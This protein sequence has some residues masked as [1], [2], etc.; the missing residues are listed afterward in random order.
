MK[1]KIL[2]SISILII[3][4]IAIRLVS[5]SVEQKK[6][7]NYHRNFPKTI[8]LWSNDF[9]QNDTIPIKFTGLG[10]NVSPSLNWVNLPSDTKSLAVIVVDYDAPSP[11]IKIATINHWIIFNIHPDINHIDEAT[12]SEELIK[13]GMKLGINITGGI[14]YVGPNPPLGT[15]NYYFRIYALSIQS[16]D[17][18]KPTKKELMEKMK[19]NIIAYG[20]LIGKYK[21]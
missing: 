7:F 3:V 9:N 19:G 17:L 5:V 13:K 21:K 6:E 16:L 18:D 8:K 11:A 14:N 20:E 4:A 10:D 1:K 2:I 12:P 15:H